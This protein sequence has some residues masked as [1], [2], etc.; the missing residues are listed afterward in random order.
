MIHG[1][2]RGGQQN[3]LQ[4]GSWGKRDHPRNMYPR[5]SINNLFMSCKPWNMKC[6]LKNEKLKRNLLLADFVY[7]NIT[8]LVHHPRYISTTSLVSTLLINLITDFL[9]VPNVFC[10]MEFN[11]ILYNILQSIPYQKEKAY[12][13]GEK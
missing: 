12:L 5:T 7:Y 3:S 1:C 10:L 9:A 11:G 6:R 8:T 2:G 13:K 4:D